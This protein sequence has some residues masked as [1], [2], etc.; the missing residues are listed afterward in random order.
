MIEVRKKEGETPSALFFRFSRR[1][2]QSG[3][4]MEARKRRFY[5]R[6]VNRRK[7]R[8]AAEYRATKKTELSRQRKLGLV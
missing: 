1:I 4:L 5:G 8:L 3:V 6:V 7:R 2:K